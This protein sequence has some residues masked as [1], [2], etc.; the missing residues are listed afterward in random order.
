MGDENGDTV[1]GFAI[2]ANEE[3]EWLLASE[4]CNSNEECEIERSDTPQFFDENAAARS[5]GEIDDA[6]V[7]SWKR[8][9]ERARA[10]E[11]EISI[12]ESF[13]PTLHWSANEI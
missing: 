12:Y 2:S 7:H 9:Y 1:R 4:T 3:P 11:R 13:W 5:T 6:L 8:R 10:E